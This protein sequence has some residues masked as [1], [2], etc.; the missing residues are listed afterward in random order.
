[1]HFVFQDMAAGVEEGLD[2]RAVIKKYE[3]SK[4]AK[5]VIREQLSYTGLHVPHDDPMETRLRQKYAAERVEPLVL[6]DRE[7]SVSM[8][9]LEHDRVRIVE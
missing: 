8:D 9:R 3:G 2:T 4:T 6:S 7:F 5:D 1:M